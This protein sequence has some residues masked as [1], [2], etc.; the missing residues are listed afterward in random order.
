MG[1]RVVERWQFSFA[2][3][4]KSTRGSFGVIPQPGAITR[5]VPGGTGAP[6]GGHL[7]VATT[8]P[9]PQHVVP[10]VDDGHQRL[11]K[12]PAEGSRGVDLHS[13]AGPR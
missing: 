3:I 13:S 6:D 4:T 7:P 5:N 1:F 10:L 2:Q 11:G 9:R 8:V 12:K